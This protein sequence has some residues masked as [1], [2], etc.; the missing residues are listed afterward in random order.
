MKICIVGH[1]FVGKAVEYGFTNREVDITIVDPKYNTS[2]KDYNVNSFDVI[3]VCVPTPMGADGSI[4]SK[5]LINVLTHINSNISLVSPLIVV[6][7]T[8]TPDIADK[9]LS[10]HPDLVYNPEFLREK[11]AIEDFVN[12]KFHIFGGMQ[13]ACEDLSSIYKKYSLCSPCPEL[14]T[15]AAEASYIKYTINSFL[16]LKVAFFNQLYDS[17]SSSNLNANFSTIIKGIEL[18]HRVGSSHTKVPGFDF[19]KGFGGSCFPKDTSAFINYDNSM[20]ILKEAIRVNN[21]YRKQYSL[22]QR[23]SEQN[24]KFE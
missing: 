1:G 11:T 16:A 2:I 3:F 9:Y 10:H 21:N 12:P 15:S 18:D 7:S 22:D 13:T 8:V 23:E 5:I 14:I 20:S 24:V 17:V 19:K 4:D 6:K